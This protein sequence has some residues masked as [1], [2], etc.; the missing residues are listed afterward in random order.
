MLATETLPNALVGYAASAVG[1]WHLADR[2][3][4][5]THPLAAGYSY[6]AGSMYNLNVDLFGGGYYRWRKN[7]NGT[8]LIE[9]QYATS[10][11]ADDAILRSR[12]MA[13]P[14]FL[15]VAFNAPHVPTHEPPATLCPGSC[16]SSFCPPGSGDAE[17]IKAALEAFDTEVGRVLG[18]VD[19]N[20]IV[21]LLGDNGSTS[22]VTEPPFDPTHAKGTVYQGGVHIPLIVAGPG[23]RVGE[24]DALVSTVDLPA[25][26]AELAGAKMI[27]PD[28][29]SFAPIL[30][31]AN[32]PA[33]R[34]TMYTERFGPNF[35]PT[36]ESFAPTWH[37]RAIRNG[38]Y[39]VLRLSD[40]SATRVEM[41]D[42]LVDPH[43]QHN[44]F[45]PANA[46]ER[47]NYAQLDDV[48]VELGVACAADVDRDGD[49][50]L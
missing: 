3:Q 30:F 35:D 32:A 40:G 24:T 16:A 42:L 11:T 21:V 27:T 15:Y 45:P 7:V 12:V 49:V 47:E 18:G 6:F 39:K 17:R 20:A 36:R 28:S 38:Q 2:N 1:K 43:E 19:P 34:T 29:V 33:P 25:T 41:Y 10:D 22:A 13:P 5:D 48:L 26:I 46:V 4:G 50:D 23:V 31:D 14:W 44:L 8:A 37:E 9:T